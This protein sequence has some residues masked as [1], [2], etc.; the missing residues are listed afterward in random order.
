VAST[1]TIEARCVNVTAL[2]Q[3]L[4]SRHE[5]DAFLAILEQLSD[6]DLARVQREHQATAD[7][8]VTHR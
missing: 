4:L 5:N 7:T 1:A 3:T 2:R 6:E 8:G